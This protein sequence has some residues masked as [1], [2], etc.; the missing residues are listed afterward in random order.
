MIDGK[1]VILRDDRKIRDAVKISYSMQ[2]GIGFKEFRNMPLAMRQIIIK[3]LK[4]IQ[5]EL[6]KK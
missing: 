4:V 2:G 3:E 5:K 6:N 1:E